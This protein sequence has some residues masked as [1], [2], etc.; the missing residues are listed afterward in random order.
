MKYRPEVD[1]LR[2]IAVLA[3]VI[4]HAKLGYLSGGF[5][6][7]DVFFV[8]SGFLITKN[9]LSEQNNTGFSLLAFYDRRARRLLPVLF[10]VLMVSCFY[11]WQYLLPAD[12]VDFSGSALSAIGFISNVFF[13]F[14]DNYHAAESSAKP[15]LHTWSLGLEEQF[16]LIFP[17]ALI[18]LAGATKFK[19]TVFFASAIIVS[20]CLAQ[21]ASKHFTEFSFFLLPTRI[22]ELL[23][24]AVLALHDPDSDSDKTSFIGSIVSLTGL[25][26]IISTFVLFDS[27]TLHPSF[28]T[29]LPVLGATA[30]IGWGRTCSIT[31]VIL[32]NSI[33]TWLGRLSYSIYLWHFPIFAFAYIKEGADGLSINHVLALLFLTL[34]LS[35]LSYF[36]IERPFRNKELL[37]TKL[38]YGLILSIGVT[39]CAWSLMTIKHDGFENRLGDIQS[40]FEGTDRNDSFLTKDGE[41]CFFKPQSR[42]RCRFEDF[43]ADRNIINMGDSH[44]NM[45]SVPLHQFATSNQYNFYN[46]ILSHCPYIEGARRTTGFKAKCE[47][48]QME[49]IKEYLESIPPSIIVY[50]AR[51]PMYLN[52]EPFDNGEGGKENSLHFPFRPDEKASSEGH[53][54]EE[55]IVLSFERMAAMGHTVILVYPTPEV[56]W[57]IPSLIK[58]RLDDVPERPVGRKRSVFEKMSITTSYPVYKNRTQS[59]KSILDQ[60]SNANVHRVY[61]EKL[62]CSDQTNRC[63]THDKNN[64]FYYDDDHLSQVGASMLVDQISN[65]IHALNTSK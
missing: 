39:I 25:L 48:P 6:G 29:L 27:N 5:F 51:W 7:V 22:W 64:I 21:Y 31:R 16:Y 30:I 60:I 26:L 3:V 36:L 47:T 4:Y 20:L 58:K 46:M 62:F 13:Y 52:K 32:G 44:A 35:V 24:G 53:Q 43:A 56:G 41:K 1:G 9:I 11:A 10:L 33:S 57:H 63:R 42:S 8:I 50:T 65:A 61:P 55:L 59:T 23:F 49:A 37:P 34:T 40:I 28:L 19:K 2:A 17:I 12:L 15:L 45:I 14:Q 54:I 18:L 38:A